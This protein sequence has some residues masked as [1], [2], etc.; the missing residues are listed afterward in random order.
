[1]LQGWSF[2]QCGQVFKNIKMRKTQK[3]K[4]K[5]T[6]GT[7][8]CPFLRADY[9]LPVS[10]CPPRGLF[11]FSCNDVISLDFRLFIQNSIIVKEV[12]NF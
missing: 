2:G 7:C 9:S 5:L 8:H 11:Y 10:S 4:K 1:M 12:K 6:K 3:K